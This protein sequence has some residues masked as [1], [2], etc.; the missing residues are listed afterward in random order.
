[1][2]EYAK[3]LIGL[4]VFLAAVSVWWVVMLI[5]RVRPRCPI[6]GGALGDATVEDEDGVVAHLVCRRE[7]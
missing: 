6:C 3:A 5:K 4:S 7:P 1:M 2:T